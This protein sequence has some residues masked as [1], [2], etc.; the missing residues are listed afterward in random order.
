MN[1]L[2]KRPISLNEFEFH[3]DFQKQSVIGQLS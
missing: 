2:P 3:K 1:N